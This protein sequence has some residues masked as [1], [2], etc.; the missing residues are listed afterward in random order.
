MSAR[1]AGSAL[2]EQLFLQTP[3]AG[4]LTGPDCVM[5]E[6]IEPLSAT[7]VRVYL[8]VREGQVV[9]ARYQV[10]GCPFT[11]AAL[12][13]LAPQWAGSPA[14]SLRVDADGLERILEAPADRRGRF[15]LIE[16]ALTQALSACATVLA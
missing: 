2:V 16:D 12:A 1:V 11:I 9:Q 5:G 6:A 14:A 13:I 15:L 7:H 8:Q 4:V 10:R 3:G